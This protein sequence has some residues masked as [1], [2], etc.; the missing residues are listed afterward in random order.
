MENSKSSTKEEV[1][2]SLTPFEK[3]AKKMNS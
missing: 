3:L 2:D 1:V